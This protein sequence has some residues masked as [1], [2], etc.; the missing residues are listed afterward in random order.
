[1]FRASL[2]DTNVEPGEESLEVKLVEEDGIPW[3]HIAFPV[4]RETLMR[5]FKDRETSNFCFHM[6]DISRGW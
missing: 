1:M 4:I 3:E 5:Y 6:G 2:V